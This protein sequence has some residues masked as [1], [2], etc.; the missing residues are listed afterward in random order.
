MEEKRQREANEKAL[1][2]E[3]AVIW[4]QDK[5]NYED[6]ERRLN[7]KVRDINKENMQFLQK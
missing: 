3:Q 1:N 2:D 6:E 4:K 5:V 7:D